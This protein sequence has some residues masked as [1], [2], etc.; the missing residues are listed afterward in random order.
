MPPCSERAHRSGTLTRRPAR[1][2]I[3]L[4]TEIADRRRC[5]SGLIGGNGMDVKEAV[6]T[7]K[8]YVVEIFEGES[9]ENLGLEEVVYDGEAVVWKMTVGFNRPWDQ[10][11]NLADALSA[12]SEG[13]IPEWRKRSYKIVQIDDRTGK[14]ISMTNRPPTI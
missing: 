9:I 2:D 14:V 3:A 1:V 6:E 10:I 4:A 8:K 7:S 11:K 13:Q 5:D 12:A